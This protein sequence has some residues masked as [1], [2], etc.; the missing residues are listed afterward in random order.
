M[1]GEMRIDPWLDRE[2][3]SYRV[4]TRLGRGGIGAVYLAQHKSIGKQVAIKCLNARWSGNKEMALRFFR[5]ARASNDINHPNIIDVLD[6]G[7]TAD[8]EQ[9]IIMEFLQGQSLADAIDEGAPFSEARASKIGR[10]MCAA[11]AAAHAR[12]IVHRDLKPENV[13][14][15]PRGEE[16]DFVKVLDF[17]IAKLMY[18]DDVPVQTAPGIVLGTPMYMAPEQATK[19]ESDPT[20][21]IYALGLMMYQMVT[22]TFPFASTNRIEAVAKNISQPPPPPSSRNTSLSA[23]LEAVIMR[24]LETKAKRYPTM[25]AVSEALSEFDS[26][27]IPTRAAIQLTPPPMEL[28]PGRKRSSLIGPVV[29]ALLVCG[30]WAA[31]SLRPVVSAPAETKQPISKPTSAQTAK[32]PALTAAAPLKEE[33]PSSTPATQSAVTTP[34]KPTKPTKTKPEHDASKPENDSNR[35]VGGMTIK[36]F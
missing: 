19:G 6:F 11:L 17:G 36:V 35:P 12:G 9:Y 32:T 14:L 3:G 15:C 26:S 34:K 4:L 20:I 18:D 16:R 27:I 33:L 23:P 21:D 2:I 30:V 29:G 31:T 5:E 7:E 8:G 10:Q 28:Q 1:T 22:G 25:Q 13:F 24:C